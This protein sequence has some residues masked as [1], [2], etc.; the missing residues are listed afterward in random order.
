MNPFDFQTIVLAWIVLA[1]LLLPIQLKITA[2]YG[3]HTNRRWGPLM[4]NRLGWMIMEVVSP[5]TLLYFFLNGQGNKPMLVWILVGLWVAHY[6]HR[7]FIFPLR[8]RTAGKQIPVAVVLS[9]VFFNTIN[10]WTNGYELG[11]QAG[12]STLWMSSPHFIVGLV[13]FLA[14][15]GLNI[16]ADNQLLKL[17]KP[18]E[19]AY[20]IPRGGMFRYL[21]CPNHFG[22]I[23]EWGGFALMAWNLPA[24]GFAIWTAAN[25][26]PRSLSHHRWYQAHF[27]DYPKERKAVIP[28]L[29]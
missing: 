13:L 27:P 25:L 9:A 15:A 22:E 18:G 7:S 28:F 24:L 12:D 23:V 20:R 10:G 6:V 29:L 4:D 2:P 26:I 1:L 3:R 11:A 14:G 16:Q 17:R 19:A 8:T 21:S 5:L